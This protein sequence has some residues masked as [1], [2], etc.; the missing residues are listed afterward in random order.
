MHI[1]IPL[2]ATIVA[3]LCLWIYTTGREI[4]KWM[5]RIR[6][7]MADGRE[8]HAAEVEN[9]LGTDLDTAAIYCALQRLEE[10]GEL[11]SRVETYYLHPRVYYK[12]VPQLSMDRGYQERSLRYHGS[13][14]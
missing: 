7:L 9:E 8:R 14:A 4:H 6:P 11:S 5:D 1:I 12:A 2:L 13:R 3:F 10:L